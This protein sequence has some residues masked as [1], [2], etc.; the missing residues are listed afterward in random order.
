[1][2][3]LLPALW[4]CAA[5]YP[6][7]SAAADSQANK[8]IIGLLA[9]EPHWLNQAAAISAK[10]NHE[11]GLRIVPMLGAG[12]VQAYQDL[13]QLNAVDAALI[14]ADSLQYASQQKLLNGAPTKY[15]YIARLETLDVVLVAKRNITSVAGLAGK[16]IATGPAQSAAFATGELIF[17]TL[18]IP[19]T[20]VA[21]QDEAA[22]DAL[23]NGTADAA[24][25]LGTDFSTAALSDGQYHVLSLPLNAK[26]NGLYQPAMMSSSDLPGLVQTGHNIET[27]STALVLAVGDHSRDALHTESLQ[28]FEDSLFT[29]LGSDSGAN[30]A[31]NVPGWKRQQQAQK[32]LG[33]RQIDGSDLINI[34]P[35][36]GKP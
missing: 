13:M 19:F 26:F 31:A 16:R 30:L 14:S 6:L 33:Q 9:A 27:V 17:G 5:L 15:S 8:H 32:L 28:V 2:R 20:R 3:K 10:L 1:M 4:V 23:L 24:L 7:S 18:A 12:G 11:N 36:G 35:T 21:K 25:I 22:I 34:I 29:Y